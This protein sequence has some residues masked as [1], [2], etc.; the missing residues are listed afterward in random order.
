M[1]NF[2]VKISYSKRR[3]LL[4][5]V[6]DCCVFVKAPLRTRI[7]KINNFLIKKRSWIENAIAKQEKNKLLLENFKQR[8][9]VLL[10]GVTTSVNKYNEECDLATSFVERIFWEFVVLYKFS[11]YEL[12]FGNAKTVWGTCTANNRVRLNKKL[13]ML[14]K[15]LIEYV[16]I[17]EL[18][19]TV[20]HNHSRLFWNGVKKICPNCSALRKALKDYSWVLGCDV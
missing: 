7:E 13:I 18:V 10:F 15:E 17:H 19:H 6:K 16:I 5:I 9:E 8:G 14:P 11:V 20:H 3:T 12:S 2:Q 1:E 4:I